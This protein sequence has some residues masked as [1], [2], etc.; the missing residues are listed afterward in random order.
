MLDGR[1]ERRHADISTSLHSE[2]ATTPYQTAY[3]N[4]QPDEDIDGMSYR[5]LRLH[6]LMI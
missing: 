3:V 2:D 1:P 5:V 4:M 6:R